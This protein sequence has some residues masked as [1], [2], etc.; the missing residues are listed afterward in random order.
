MGISPHSEMLNDTHDTM[1]L[2]TH[3]PEKNQKFFAKHS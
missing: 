1:T 2:D 3:A